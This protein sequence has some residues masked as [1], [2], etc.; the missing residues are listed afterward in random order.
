MVDSI[1]NY[2]L[3]TR[4]ITKI[5]NDENTDVRKVVGIFNTVNPLA[6]VINATIDVPVRIVQTYTFRPIYKGIRSVKHA[7]KSYDCK[8]YNITYPIYQQDEVEVKIQLYD[9][10]DCWST[11]IEIEFIITEYV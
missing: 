1:S 4:R 10:D 9:W 5:I 11:A 6:W 8:K 2:S 3:T 7:V